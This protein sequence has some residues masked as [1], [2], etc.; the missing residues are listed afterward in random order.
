MSDDNYQ[1]GLLPGANPFQDLV[2]DP[3]K[4]DHRELVDLVRRLAGRWQAAEDRETVWFGRR[5]TA[6]LSGPADGDLT[7]ALGLRPPT[8]SHLTAPAILS[9]E[10]RDI[11]MLELSL[12]AGGY[13]AALRLLKSGALSPEW[14]ELAKNPPKSAAAFTR[15]LKRVSLRPR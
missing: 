2:R 4:M 11:A 7:A 3:D 12:A 8:G 15:A 5:L 6:W 14:A 1:S 10:K 13:R 9:Q